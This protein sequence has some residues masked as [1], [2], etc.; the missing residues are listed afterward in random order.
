MS[1]KILGQ[2]EVSNKL[3]A[4]AWTYILLATLTSSYLEH[5]KNQKQLYV[6]HDL[7]AD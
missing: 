3:I 2:A 4:F 5:A 7:K 1:D 6:I